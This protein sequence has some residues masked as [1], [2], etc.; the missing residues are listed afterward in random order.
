VSLTFLG[1]SNDLQ[2]IGCD[3]LATLAHIYST[4]L[5][6]QLVE[7]ELSL[8]DERAMRE[9]NLQ[10]RSLDEPTD[11]LSFPTYTGMAG[12]PAEIPLLIGGIAL[13]PSKA[14]SYG[15]SLPQLV[16]HGLL[17]LMGYDHEAEPGTWA[18]QEQFILADLTLAGL[19]LPAVPV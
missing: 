3:H 12:F 2:A 6:N 4:Y 19:E 10:T 5:P 1:N 17:H 14:E 9:L 15:E 8:L 16:H 13:C 7:V 11:V 18:T